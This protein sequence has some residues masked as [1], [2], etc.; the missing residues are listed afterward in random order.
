MVATGA[1]SPPPPP[2]YHRLPTPSSM[3]AQSPSSQ[4]FR[5]HHLTPTTPFLLTTNTISRIGLCTIILAATSR[6]ISPSPI[7]HPCPDRFP[8]GEFN[9]GEEWAIV[10]WRWKVI[11]SDGELVVESDRRRW[12]FGSEKWPSSAIR[13]GEGTAR[14]I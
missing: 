6:G 13:Q 11:D 2:P 4:R 1:P 7:T 3:T 10:I 14:R 5:T 9:A 12:R 8:I